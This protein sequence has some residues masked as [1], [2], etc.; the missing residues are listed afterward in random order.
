MFNFDIDLTGKT[1]LAVALFQLFFVLTI[2]WSVGIIVQCINKF[3]VGTHQIFKQGDYTPRSNC[4][5]KR[6]RFVI[7]KDDSDGVLKSETFYTLFG[8][9]THIEYNSGNY[10]SLETVFFSSLLLM[11][12]AATGLLLIIIGNLQDLTTN[13]QTVTQLADNQMLRNCGL[14]FFFPSLISGL[15]KLVFDFTYTKL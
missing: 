1:I 5:P 13:T 8:D 10:S 3:T 11:G 2:G 4:Y 12:F 15:I 14:V 6:Y 7:V 9:W